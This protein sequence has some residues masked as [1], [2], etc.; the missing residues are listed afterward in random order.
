MKKYLFFFLLTASMLLGA[1]SGKDKICR[2]QVTGTNEYETVTSTYV[3][4]DVD[5][6]VECADIT[7]VGDEW[8]GRSR[9][10][11]SQIFVSCSEE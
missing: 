2:C 3:M 9:F 4:M 1:C 6:T 7:M 8:L 5:G 10:E 11:M